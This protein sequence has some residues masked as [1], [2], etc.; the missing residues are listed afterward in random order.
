MLWSPR[1]RFWITMM[2]Q[3]NIWTHHDDLWV[4]IYLSSNRLDNYKKLIDDTVYKEVIPKIPIIVDWRFHL[5]VVHPESNSIIVGFPSWLVTGFQ[6]QVGWGTRLHSQLNTP[7][8]QW[9]N[10]VGEDIT[11]AAILGTVG[12][13]GVRQLKML[14]SRSS[15]G[16]K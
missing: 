9:A 5:V 16:D 12:K 15:S 1:T 2:S 6:E 8:P 14:F 7:P 4:S 10:L 3:C 13:G 11:T